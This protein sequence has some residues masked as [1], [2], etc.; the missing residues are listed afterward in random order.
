MSSLEGLLDEVCIALLD[1]ILINFRH[2]FKLFHVTWVDLLE[3]LLIVLSAF[4]NL[5]IFLA[6]NRFIYFLRCI[7]KATYNYF[8][9]LFMAGKSISYI[10]IFID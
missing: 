9:L 8:L 2:E 4:I 5:G 10:T 6:R 3:I 1:G 7:C